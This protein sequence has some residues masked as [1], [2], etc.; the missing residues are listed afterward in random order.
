MNDHQ[1]LRCQTAELANE[2][3]SSQWAKEP[4][5]TVTQTRCIP[6]RRH[7][8]LHPGTCEQADDTRGHWGSSESGGPRS[9]AGRSPAACSSSDWPRR[10]MPAISSLSAMSYR[11]S[12]VLV[13]GLPATGSSQLL[14]SCALGWRGP[15][16]RAHVPA[17]FTHIPRSAQGTNH[18]LSDLFSPF[19]SW[20]QRTLRCGTQ[21]L[22]QTVQNSSQ[23][24]LRFA[25]P[26]RFRCLS[27]VVPGFLPLLSFSSL[28]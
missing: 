17:A 5:S 15:G 24:I 22:T 21:K 2:P 13:L 1:N 8:P 7:C 27:E 28:N 3:L 11:H 25:R 16:R 12:Q 14:S 18:F 10:F 6:V 23:F 20:T 4:L 26:L 9:A 19:S